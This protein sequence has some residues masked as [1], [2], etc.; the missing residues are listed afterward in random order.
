MSPLDLLNRLPAAL[1]DKRFLGVLPVL[2]A[3]LIAYHGL[4]VPQSFISSTVRLSE[5][6]RWFFSPIETGSPLILYALAAWLTVRRL[7]KVLDFLGAP[8]S[9]LLPG[10][11]CLSALL[12]LIWARYTSSPGILVFSLSVFLMACGHLLAGHQGRRALLLPAVFL[13][14]LAV[15]LPPV[16]VNYLILPLQLWTAY[17]TTALLNLIGIYAVQSGDLILTQKATFQVIETCSGLRTV[18]TLLMATFVY[19]EVFHRSRRRLI[20]L[21]LISPIIG[22]FVNLLRVMSLVLNPEGDHTA[23]HMAQ[24]IFMLI[25]GV[26]IISLIDR[27]L[28]SLSPH[29]SVPI[30]S[31]GRFLVKNA[32]YPLP[33]NRIFGITT[34][35][36]LTSLISSQISPWSK[37]NQLEFDVH[38][39]SQ[40]L[41]DWKMKKPILIPNPMYLGTTGFSLKTFRGYR[42][43]NGD[44]IEFFIGKNDRTGKY[45]SLLSDKTKT[46]KAG[47][48]IIKQFPSQRPPD[49][50]ALSEFVIEESS[51]SRWLVHHWYEGLESVPMETLR[52][53]AGLDRSPLRRAANATVIRIATPVKRDKPDYKKARE[54]INDF[55]KALNANLAQHQE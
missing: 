26:L 38:I 46:L 33:K 31:S 20:L 49:G 21:L 25:G 1:A 16:F 4:L 19:A 52:S 5:A 53:A 37:P 42:R 44:E 39:I 41:G 9:W 40:N 18:Q 11:G 22:L 55:K 6:E 10:V 13:T 3:I 28:E 48:H 8:T 36:I 23:L 7:P 32:E 35:L 47:R 27:I 14:L 45:M 34:L 12:L 54:R 2:I 50:E 51:G 17:L 24:G 15:P 29:S 43:P 30:R